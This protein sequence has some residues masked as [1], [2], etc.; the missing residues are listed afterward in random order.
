MGILDDLAM[1]FGMKARTEDYDAR[2][3]RNLAEYQ[4]NERAASQYLS[5]RGRGADYN[6]AI[7]QDDRPFMQRLLFSQQGAESPTPYAIGPV[8]MGGPIK[9]PSALGLLGAIFGGGEGD[10]AP[11]EGRRQ[12]TQAPVEGRRQRDQ[13]TTTQVEPQVEPQTAP[14]SNVTQQMSDA[15]KMAYQHYADTREL[16]NLEM[17]QSFYDAYGTDQSMFPDAARAEIAARRSY[18]S[19]DPYSYMQFGQP[20][21]SQL[22]QTQYP[23]DPDVSFAQYV[24]MVR[25]REAPHVKS[26]RLKQT[27]SLPQLRESYNKL[28]GF[29]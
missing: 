23:Q 5:S 29:N 27:Q 4:G 7:A 26:G 18:L 17:P 21:A 15:Q 12:Q 19:P 10:Q 1:G 8:S 20:P 2:T 11:V 28:F 24:D 16:G 25:R 3:A 6:P 13:G 9:F 14:I 22:T